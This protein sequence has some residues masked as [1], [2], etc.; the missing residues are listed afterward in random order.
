MNIN[1]LCFFFP[2]FSFVLNRFWLGKGKQTFTEQTIQLSITISR[3][4]AAMLL[5]LSLFS[6]VLRFDGPPAEGGEAIGRGMQ[7]RE[8]G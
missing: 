2:V 6:W 4:V 8:K 7:I 3:V 1:S 5:L